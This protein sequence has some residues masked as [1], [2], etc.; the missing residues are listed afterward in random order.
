MNGML[1]LLLLSL[2]AL[3]GLAAIDYFVMPP[4]APVG[5]GDDPQPLWQV[6]TAFLLRALENISAMV[7]IG[8]VLLGAA[9][10]IQRWLQPDAQP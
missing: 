5:W 4:T 10:Y 8:I 7:V 1:K 6:E 2:A 3:V 9:F